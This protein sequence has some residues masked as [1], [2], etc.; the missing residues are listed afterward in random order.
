MSHTNAELKEAIIEV[1][2]SSETP[3]LVREITQRL[4]RARGVPATKDQIIRCLHS[5]QMRGEVAQ[6]NSY[7]WSLAHRVNTTS[8]PHKSTATNAPGSVQAALRTAT[9]QDRFRRLLAYYLDCIEEDE[10]E[11]A[12]FFLADEGRN[13]LTFPFTKE[14]SLSETATA[15]IPVTPELSGFAKQLRQRGSA[16]ALYYGYPVYVDWFAKA[17]SGW[18]GG[19]GL[20]LFLQGVEFELTGRTLQLKLIP[21]WPRPNPECLRKILSNYEER[22]DF[23]DSLGLISLDSEPPENGLSDIIRRMG[24]I[25]VPADCMELLDPTSL[26]HNPALAD[27]TSGGFYNRAVMSLGKGQ[28]LRRGSKK[29]WSYFAPR[30]RALPSTNRLP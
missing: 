6:N 14:W 23:L 10:S 17:K 29:N 24:E 18:T 3:L 1:L 5:P 13:Y 7:R 12:R 26:P 19:F 28:N 16:A 8:E 27:L 11:G 30:C 22:R 4:V 25:G 9:S 21:E 2:S 15:N 20:P